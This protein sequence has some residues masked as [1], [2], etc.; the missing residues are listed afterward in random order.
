VVV[1]SPKGEPVREIQLKGK[2]PTNLVF[3]KD[4]KTVYVTIQDRGMVE[5][6]RVP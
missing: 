5:K 6:F 3:S 1:L 2:D 4:G